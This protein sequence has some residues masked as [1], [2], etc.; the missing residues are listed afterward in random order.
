MEVSDIRQYRWI[1]DILVVSYHIA[2]EVSKVQCCRVILTK[3][4]KIIHIIKRHFFQIE[5]VDGDIQVADVRNFNDFVWSK[6]GQI[7][8]FINY[9]LKD[10]VDHILLDIFEE[11]LFKYHF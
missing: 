8:V 3:G 5:F 11:L 7:S 10:L 4:N 6:W 9:Y 2:R 1:S